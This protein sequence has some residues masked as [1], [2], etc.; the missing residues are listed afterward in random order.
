MTTEQKEQ[1]KALKGTRYTNDREMSN[2]IG[3]IFGD[4]LT[5][6]YN[7]RKG[8]CDS[9]VIDCEAATTGESVSLFL[10]GMHDTIIDVEIHEAGEA[11][12]ASEYGDAEYQE[13]HMLSA[14]VYAVLTGKMP[15]DEFQ[16]HW[17]TTMSYSESAAS[18]FLVG[19]NQTDWTIFVE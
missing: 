17:G 16:K 9:V 2:I 19:A 6:T 7:A 3:R 13:T 12:S 15:V 4:G 10:H 5:I 11:P 1:F 8:V 14:D 18:I